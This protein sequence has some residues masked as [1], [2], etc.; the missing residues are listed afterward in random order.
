MEVSILFENDD[1]LVIN[2]PAGLM[3]HSDGKREEKT[4]ADWIIEKYPKLKGVGEPVTF[5]EKEIDRP[6]IV[7][8]LDEETSGVLIVVK[9][10]EAFAYFKKQF[11]NRE[12]KKEYHAFVWGYF[13]EPSGVIE[14]PIGRNKNDFR[15]WHAGRGTR[16]ELRDAVTHW[17]VV[18][19]FMDEDC[20]DFSFVQLYPKTGRTHQLRVH[21][22]YLQRPLVSDHL[23]APTKPEALGF[24]RVALHARKISF[25][26]QKGQK[27][28]VEAPYPADFQRAVVK[29]VK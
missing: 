9:T 26:D 17:E 2:K 18:K 6:G 19:Q 13:K 27:I 4:I 21:M 29:Y 11:M 23:Y 14:V 22:K 3:V 1:F 7:H 25:F 28:E 15:R 24:S 10:K 16:G 12:I 20:Q 8:R 5:D